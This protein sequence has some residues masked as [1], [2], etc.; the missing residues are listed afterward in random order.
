MA[1][2]NTEVRTKSGT[3]SI[4]WLAGAIGA[5]VGIAALAYSRKRQSP[6]DRTKARASQLIDTARAEAKPWMGVAAGTAAASTALAVYARSR[7]ESGWQSAGTRAREVASR[8]GTQTRPWANLALSAA[9]A[10]ASAASSRKARR[11]TIRGINES[12][13]D[14]INALTE[15][16]QRLVRRVRDLS[17]ETRKVY[18][19]IRRV[20]A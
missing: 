20:I 11:R 7:K 6:W 13:A 4:A 14:T 8:V 16:G 1:P 10:L 2:D 19:S 15:K 17:Q 3:R 5:S 9:I 18:P 12:T